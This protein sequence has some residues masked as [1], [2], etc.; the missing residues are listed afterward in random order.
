VVG[1]K[2]F[3][4]GM[5]V[6]IVRSTGMW[7]TKRNSAKILGIEYVVESCLFEGILFKVLDRVTLLRCTHR[8]VRKEKEEKKSLGPK[9]TI[10][11]PHHA[12]V[13]FRSSSNLPRR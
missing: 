8:V 6:H 4:P 2:D 10:P 7:R 12:I 5:H 13:A 9:Y 1:L 11:P 3:F